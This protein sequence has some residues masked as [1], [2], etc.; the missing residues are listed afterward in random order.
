MKSYHRVYDCGETENIAA[1][2]NSRGKTMLRKRQGNILWSLILLAISLNAFSKNSVL[3]NRIEGQVYS[4]NRIPVADVNIELLNDVDSVFARTRTNAAGHFS[5]SGMPPGRFNVKVLPYGTNFVEQTQEVQ[6]TNI[7]N[8]YNDTEYVDIYLRYDK[9]SATAS[10]AMPRE[11]VLA[12]EI[13]AD[14]KKLFEEGL[15]DF[16]KNQA[17]GTAK[18]EEA[19]KIF[20]EYFDALHWL[21]KIYISQKSYEKGYP[22]LL[23]A[24][25]INSRSYSSYY[26][27]GV[28][29]YQLKQYPA[30]LEAARASVVLS[31]DSIEAHLL[32]GTILRITGSYPE[33]EKALVKANTLAKK[34]NSEA[35][36]QLALLYNRLNRNQDAIGELETF[37][38]LVPDS[39]DK[40][41]VKEMLAKLKTSA[42]K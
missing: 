31:P 37:L 6:V 23:R 24:I 14:A 8:T 20:P 3:I 5:F 12:Q 4:P 26:N 17:K 1:S 21:G 9:Q 29:F 13:P 42:N 11:V 33:A 40:N 30:A 2:Q 39:P 10:S 7:G 34:T 15:A 36:W 32:S 38:K 28:A 18:L 41:K 27:L 35:H 22:Y 25:D 19:I 16:A